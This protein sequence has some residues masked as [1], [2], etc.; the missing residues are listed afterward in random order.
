MMLP[1]ECTTDRPP[2]KEETHAVQQIILPGTTLVLPRFVFGTA[3]LFSA[4]ARARRLRLLDAAV[5][6]GLTHFDTAL[7]MASVLPNVTLP[8]SFAETRMSR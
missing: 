3:N 4:G 8:P 6:H 2:D 5:A 7:I 1:I